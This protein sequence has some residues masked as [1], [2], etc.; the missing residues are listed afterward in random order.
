MEGRAELRLER[1]RVELAL[2][3]VIG[4]ELAAAATRELTTS[5]M[6]ETGARTE[7]AMELT[8]LSA[9][10]T[11]VAAAKLQPSPE[12]CVARSGPD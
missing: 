11:A 12:A 4:V 3:L 7:E 6:L 5:S 2:A 9:L 8:A 1:V 10:E